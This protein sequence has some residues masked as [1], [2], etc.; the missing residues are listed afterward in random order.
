MITLLPTGMKTAGS[1]WKPV[2]RL[3]KGVGNCTLFYI[4]V[5]EL[6]MLFMFGWLA[7][8]SLIVLLGNVIE[9]EYVIGVGASLLLAMT[10]IVAVS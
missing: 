2:A 9:N 3:F 6:V 1:I 7:F 8:A 4:V 10:A 5:K